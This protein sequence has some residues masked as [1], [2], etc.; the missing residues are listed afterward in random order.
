MTLVTAPIIGLE[1]VQRE[2]FY[3]FFEGINPAIV[4]VAD[5][6]ATSDETFA[7]RTGRPY[8]ATV[9]EPIE[10][11]NIY[12]GHRPSLI[13]A[14]VDRYPNCS[15]WTVRAVPAPGSASL[16]QVSVYR[17]LAFV[18][19]MVKSADSE[20]E[21]NRRLLRTVE[22]ANIVVMQDPTLGGTVHGIDD[23]VTV[24]VSDVF[25]RT[26]RTAYGPE[27]YWQGARLEYTVRKEAVLPSSSTGSIF[28]T[29]IPY[30]VDQS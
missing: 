17:D 7:V 2:L 12:E 1:Q 5:F 3:A 25:T 11:D 4:E 29:S 28:R 9:V 18:E 16:D 22:A 10:P 13:K 14:P 8:A 19:V 26:E 23:D 21:V 27:W 6:M 30:D 24:N 15:V 20:E